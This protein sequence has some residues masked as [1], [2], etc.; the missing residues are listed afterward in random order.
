MR[1]PITMH[2]FMRR[3]TRDAGLFQ[4]NTEEYAMCFG[5]MTDPHPASLAAELERERRK[6]FWLRDIRSTDLNPE[7]NRHIDA[8]LKQDRRQPV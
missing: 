7:H 5:G 3:V 2:S 1:E 8:V 6:D 4:H